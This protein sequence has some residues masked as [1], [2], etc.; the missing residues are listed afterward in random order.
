ANCSNHAVVVWYPH[1][2]ASLNLWDTAKQL[3]F[4]AHRVDL[5]LRRFDDIGASVEMKVPAE[6]VAVTDVSGDS[7]AAATRPRGALG[8]LPVT[9]RHRIRLDGEI[10]DLAVRERAA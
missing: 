3:L 1:H 10:S 8:F 9:G 6:G 5:P 4:A 7:E 2:R